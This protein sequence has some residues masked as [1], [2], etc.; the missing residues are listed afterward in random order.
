MFGVG[1]GPNAL[2]ARVSVLGSVYFGHVTKRAIVT[3]VSGEYNPLSC[4][5]PGDKPNRS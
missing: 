3:Q 1:T 5:C 2:A 4:R